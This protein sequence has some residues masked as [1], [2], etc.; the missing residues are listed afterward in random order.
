MKSSLKLML[1]NLIQIA[2]LS[3]GSMDPDDNDNMDDDDSS[4]L[5]IKTKS[6]IWDQCYDFENISPKNG[7]LMQ[8]TAKFCMKWITTLFFEKNTNFFCE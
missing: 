4:L 7:F 6:S 1:L 8:N 3:S 2:K 5:V